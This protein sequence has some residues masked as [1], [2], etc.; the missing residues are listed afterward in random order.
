MDIDLIKKRLNQLQTT[1][2]TK[3]N[4]WKPTPG[5]SHLKPAVAS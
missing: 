4:F 5:V 1:T 2:S 3:D